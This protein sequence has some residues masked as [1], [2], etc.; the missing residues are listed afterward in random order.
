MKPSKKAEMVDGSDRHWSFSEV[1]PT[2]PP[3]SNVEKTENNVA[4]ELVARKKTAGQPKYPD[5]P[6]YGTLGRRVTLYA[7]YLQLTSVGKPLKRY[8]ISIAPEAVGKKA[9]RVVSLLLEQHFKDNV[10]QIATDYRSTMVSC[11]E[12][13]QRDEASFDV[14]YKNENA[15]EYPV[16]DKLK[17]YRVTCMKTGNINPA[18]LVNYLTSTNAGAM[19]ESKPEIVQAL[20]LVLGH[21]PKTESSIVSIGANRHYSINPSIM[22]TRSLGGGLNALR[23]FFISARAATARVLLNVQVKY[24]ACYEAGSLAQVVGSFQQTNRNS[25][26]L[27]K[28]LSRLR[29][30]LTHLDRKT[31]S[32]KSRPRIKTI[33]GL[34]NPTDGRGSDIPLKVPKV[35]AGPHEVAFFCSPGGPGSPK[36]S[37][38]S[39]S[40]RKKSKKPGPKAG[41]V[42]EGRFVTVE[43]FFSKGKLTLSRFHRNH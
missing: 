37:P 1:Q 38:N 24:L 42:E 16:G 26:A 8:H 21:H 31:S 29:V 28:F 35:G 32:G 11:V 39:E 17:V 5:R 2:P 19:L 14:R 22:E 40:K 18:D 4:K 41:L 30:R 9:R 15:K 13:L 7:N 34:A 20:N 12:L 33:A 3:N 25:Y 43:Q 27:D 10:D 6:G 23:G 36:K